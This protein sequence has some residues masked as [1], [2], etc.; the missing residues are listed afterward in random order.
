MNLGRHSVLGVDVDAVD[1]DEAV[2]QILAAARNQQWLGM[3]AV[4]VHSVM[5]AVL[6]PGFAHD[7]SQMSLGVPDG[8][9]VR[10]ALRL[11][12]GTRLPDR[13][14]GP[15]LML[16]LCASAA[17]EGIPI[18]L[19]GSQPWVLDQLQH[20]LR[21]RFPELRIAGALAG[22]TGPQAG[23]PREAD[24]AAVKASGA[25][26]LFVALGCPKQEHWTARTRDR[27]AMPVVAV[28]AAFEF[29]A[30]TLAQ[31]PPLLQRL[32]LEWAFR[33]SVEPRRLW[34]RYLLLNPAYVVLVGLQ[35][36]LNHR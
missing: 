15:E 11:L 12:Y 19:F 25:K 6:D 10:W 27:L 24:L 4:P 1:Y 16:R 34:R 9:P 3:A 31:A 14:Y 18:F 28:G 17:R 35:R 5:T 30:G 2:R 7:L 36:L 13:V 22:P 21:D 23:E 29:H 26:L 32:G 20:N 33:L 8:Q